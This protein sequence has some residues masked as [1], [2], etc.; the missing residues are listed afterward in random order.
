MG[1]GFRDG[2]G[3][4]GIEPGGLIVP[5]LEHAPDPRL[6]EAGK[7]T[8]DVR[9]VLSRQLDLAGEAQV[10]TDED[11]CT[12]DDTGRK[13]LVVT[14]PQPEYPAVVILISVLDFQEAEIPGT[15]MADAVG[16][17]AYGET[18]RPEGSL[19]LGDELDVRDRMPTRCRPGC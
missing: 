9:C 16:E 3:F 14:V 17:G 19:D 13:G 7:V 10:V 18:I 11:G 12:G 5:F 6:D 4:V 8:D 2:V 1:G 15:V